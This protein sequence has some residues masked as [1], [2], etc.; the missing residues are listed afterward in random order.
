MDKIRE[1]FDKFISLKKY[2]ENEMLVGIVIYGSYATNTFNNDSDLD[3]MVIFNDEFDK[4]Y[5][6]YIKVSNLKIEYFE[7][8]KK[9]ILKRMKIDYEKC[10]NTIYSIF[11]KCIVYYEKNN[12]ITNL[13]S[14]IRQYNENNSLPRL[15]IED[16]IYKIISINNGID[17]LSRIIE[18]ISFYS[19]Y[20]VL[21]NKIVNFFHLYNGISIVSDAKIYKMYN[22]NSICSA[23]SKKTV[24]EGFKKLYIE[25][26]KITMPQYDFLN[27]QKLF[28][29]V[30]NYTEIK[31]NFNDVKIDITNKLY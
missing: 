21:L 13:I 8:S 24:D 27:I 15:S 28:E 18:E 3:V 14:K 5:K 6:G 1:S 17:H 23:L 31:I 16:S 9:N 30:I 10:E 22:N 25:S 20:F 19:Y 7:Q 2:Y 11:N 4:K 26:L 29:Y 12:E